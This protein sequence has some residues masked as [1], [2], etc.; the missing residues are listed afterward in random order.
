MGVLPR[1]EG[2]RIDHGRRAIV[3]NDAKRTANVRA[4][5]T[6][7]ELM[8]QERQSLDGTTERIQPRMIQKVLN[9]SLL[10]NPT[11]TATTTR[12]MIPW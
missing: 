2:R 5:P 12:K 10:R 11:A 7:Q 6:I 4:I 8:E 9:G 1:M 3:T